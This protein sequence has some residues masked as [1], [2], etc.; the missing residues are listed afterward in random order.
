MVIH[1]FKKYRIICISQKKTL[2]LHRIKD[3]LLDFYVSNFL[4]DY[5]EY[6]NSYSAIQWSNSN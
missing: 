6:L 1:I 3:I 4:R 5:L 2:P